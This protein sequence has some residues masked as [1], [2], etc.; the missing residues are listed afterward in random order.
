MNGA[1]NEFFAGSCFTQQQDCRIAGGNSLDEVN[2][3]PEGCALSND[4]FQ[5]RFTEHAVLQVY[6]LIET[7]GHSES[8]PRERGLAVIHVEIRDIIKTHDDPPEVTF[9]LFRLRLLSKYA[10]HYLRIR[11]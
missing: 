8:R 6:V 7:G 11:P 1:G 10:H 4:A 5:D 3:M 2:D 9:Q